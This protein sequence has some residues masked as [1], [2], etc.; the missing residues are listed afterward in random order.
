MRYY[1]KNGCLLAP[2]EARVRFLR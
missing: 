2:S 1:Y